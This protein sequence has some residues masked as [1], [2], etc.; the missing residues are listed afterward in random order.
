MQDVGDVP[1]IPKI[2]TLFVDFDWQARS[3]APERF[4]EPSLIM[5]LSGERLSSIEWLS[6]QTLPNVTER[7]VIGRVPRPSAMGKSPYVADVIT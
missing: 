4:F 6:H 3:N 5:I 2:D 1:G 7:L